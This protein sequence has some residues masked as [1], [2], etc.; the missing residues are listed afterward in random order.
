MIFR[1]NGGLKPQGLQT[2]LLCA[3]N[4]SGRYAHSFLTSHRRGRVPRGR[5]VGRIWVEDEGFTIAGFNGSYSNY[6]TCEPKNF[7]LTA[8]A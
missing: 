1:A 3:A 5:F 4:S 7:T 2:R 6:D 8:G